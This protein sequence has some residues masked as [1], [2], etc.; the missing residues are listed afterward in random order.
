MSDYTV[1]IFADKCIEQ[2]LE[3]GRT[4]HLFY[5]IKPCFLDQNRS[6]N[7]LYS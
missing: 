2:I 4:D 1:L 3:A 6:L 7:V 5:V